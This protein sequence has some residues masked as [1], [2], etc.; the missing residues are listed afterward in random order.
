[1]NQFTW[2]ELDEGNVIQSI[3]IEKLIYLWVRV[4]T[5]MIYFKMNKIVFKNIKSL[6]KG[7]MM[8]KCHTWLVVH[9]YISINCFDH[10]T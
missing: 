7:H 5:E 6:T 2:F 10:Q 4:F 1:M 3:E 9:N 8:N